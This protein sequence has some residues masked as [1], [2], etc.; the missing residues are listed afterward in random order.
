MIFAPALAQSAQGIS[1]TPAFVAMMS[2]IDLRPGTPGE[3]LLGKQ[4][5]GVTQVLVTGPPLMAGPA[6]RVT[7]G[8]TGPA[9]H[10]G[11]SG[12]ALQGL[13]FIPE[14]IPVV[15]DLGKEPR[16]QLGTGTR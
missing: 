2:V 1:V 5:D 15:A 16:G 6:G 14:A 8:F 4:M 13:R 12:Q 7:M 10:R 11:R 3:G 9:G